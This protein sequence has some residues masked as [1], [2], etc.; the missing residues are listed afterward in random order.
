MTESEDN[1]QTAF[2]GESQANRRYLFFAD[3]A[4]KEGHHQTARL[5]RAAAEA[6]LREEE[7]ERVPSTQLPLLPP[8]PA[9]RRQTTR[10]RPGRR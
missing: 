8:D 1:L 9:G 2:A 4:D 5:F 3:K 7:G 6:L 10:A